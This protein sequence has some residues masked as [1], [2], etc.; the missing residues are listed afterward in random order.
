MVESPVKA[1]GLGAL[2][3]LSQV[4]G[5]DQQCDAFSTLVKT[6][7]VC[8]LCEFD[9]MKLCQ[10][11]A[12]LSPC[13]L[14]LGLTVLQLLLVSPRDGPNILNWITMHSNVVS[15]TP[16]RD[17]DLLPLPL[18]PVGAALKLIDQL[19]TNDVGL[20]VAS[21]PK[22]V[23]GKKT[24]RQQC[25]KLVTEGTHQLWRVIHVI[26]L[27][28][29]NSNWEY[30]S[31]PKLQLTELQKEAMTNINRWVVRFCM[32]P[33]K[34]YPLPNFSELVK[35]KSIDYSGEEVAHAL[36]L[37]LEELMP[38]LPLA[39][40]AGSLSA[41]QAAAGD[42]KQWVED[43]TIT[44]KPKGSWPSKTPRARINATREEWYRVCE[45]LF[46]RG[47]IEPIALEDVFCGPEG[48]VLNGA[49]AV[50]KKGKPGEGQVRVT[51]LIMNF[52][53]TNS[54]Q[55]LMVGDLNTLAGST[56]WCQ[57]ILKPDQVLLW[58]GDDQKGAFY[59]WELPK[60]WRPFMAFVWPV[61]GHMVGSN[62]K[63]EYVASRVIP[64]GWI[65]AVS[66]FQ[67]LHRQLGMEQPPKGAGHREEFEWRRDR[68]V[69][70]TS[71][72]KVN[73][74]VQF[75]L[76]DF[77]CPEVIPS[78]GWE[79]LQGTMSSTHRLQRSSYERWGVG[80][81]TEKAHLRDPKVVRMGAEVDGILGTVSVPKAKQ[82]EAIYFGLWCMGLR[83]PPV[84][85]LLMVLGRF[86]RIFEFRRP[87]M[88]LLQSVWPKG[89]LLGRRPLSA[90]QVQELLRAM[91]VIPLS[92]ADLR[93]P[94]SN[95]VTCSDASEAGG[96]MCCSGGLTE[97]GFAALAKCQSPEFRQTRMAMFEP[98][99]ALVTGSRK[100][101]KIVVV[102]L[103]DGIAALMCALCR[104]ECQV[105]AF[106]ASEVDV[107]CKRLVRKRWPGVLEL[108][109]ITK[110]DDC[111]IHS[112]RRSVGYSVD[113]VLCGGGSPCQDLSAL[114]ADREGLA[115]SRSKLFYEMPRIFK[116]L[117]EEFDCP[118][119]TFV[120]NVF[121]MTP[122][123][124]ND[125]TKELQ[126]EPI[127]VDCT[128]FSNCRRPR[129]FWVDWPVHA[130]GDELM[131]D[132][133][134][135]QEWQF[136]S[137]LGDKKW[138]LEPGCAHDHEGPLPTFTR[139]LPRR[140]P[141]KQAAGLS[142][143]S[144]EAIERWKLDSHK[145]QVYQYES[146]HMVRKPDGSIRL[147][148]LG[149]R[150]RLM[151]FPTGY[152]STGLSTKLRL[153]EAFNLGACM[154]GNSF[155][156]YAI[157]F[158]LDELLAHC[159][160]NY[161]PRCLDLILTRTEVS[162]EGWCEHPCFN[163]SSEPDE[164]ARMLVQEFLR[165][166]DRGGTDVKLD[167]GIPFRIKAWPRAGI[168]SRL[169]HWKIINGY[170]WKH[171]SHINVLELQALVH[172]L[173]WRLRKTSRFRHRVLRLIDN[174]V[175]ASVVAKGRS[176]SFR[177]RR[178]VEKLAA[179]LI[180]GEVRLAVGY[181]ATDDNPS[182]LPSR[183]AKSK[184]TKLKKDGKLES[185]TEQAK[186]FLKR[187]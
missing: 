60:A 133:E 73:E 119:H 132:Q 8:K 56:S 81:S 101:L 160:P 36:P 156:V 61:P 59:A 47:I 168:R 3:V 99:G 39:G 15:T 70:Q 10:K 87:F 153:S 115:G 148:S 17:R 135:Y 51:R 120:E 127:L 149:E 58:S 173:Q 53:P 116:A 14:Q 91:A 6:C 140:T 163:P 20:L 77:D 79:D 2:G 130:R 122:A 143:A 40:V 165:Q 76:D 4:V 25:K 69:P 178:A 16:T 185:K 179:L 177:L 9:F 107:A 82:F 126:V 57:L 105:V 102:S 184:T 100:G 68:A 174:Q 88:C 52:V 150:E 128:A 134:G 108:G 48:P 96:G 75:Y 142:T 64:M 117:K 27:N 176:S 136:P 152:V 1:G 124:R 172:A 37:R 74:F 109:D 46:K 28:G 106:A 125:F 63:M 29:M 45:E 98:Q 183:W 26:I 94:V 22:V 67:H 151:G 155:N 83:L 164:S 30:Q 89:S 32:E 35:S 5:I 139:A 80:I 144:D 34:I 112:L 97:E 11:A 146:W 78:E 90:K 175:V 169:F 162:P 157:S 158:L 141:P 43:P 44:L 131:V 33:L 66:L 111:T 93:A 19:Q 84:K 103:F 71:D 166:G 49:F 123:S 121:S 118:V 86:V 13:V 31:C 110:I 145:F 65:Q 92:G 38:G 167:V 12:T 85:V 137:M 104:L 72:G 7:H 181:V 129:L 147:P 182:D 54:F 23:T 113:L 42:I 154:I 170:P 62:A 171:T 114:L 187:S 55:K 95:L 186:H 18:P 21:R 159:D 24:K 50:E 138:W 161:A 180:A 41:V